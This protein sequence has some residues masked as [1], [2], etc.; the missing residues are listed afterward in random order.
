MIIFNNISFCFDGRTIIDNFSEKI[1]TNEKVCLM[2][3]SGAGKSTIMQGIMGLRHPVSGEIIV[4]N[5]TLAP[6]TV[7]LIRNRIAWVPQEINLPYDSVENCAKSLFALKVNSDKFFDKNRMFEYFDNVA[8]ERNIFNKKMNE[9]SG[10]ERQRLMI[11]F[12]LLLEKKILL[13][14]E[15]TSALDSSARSMLIEFLKSLEITMLA[16]SHDENFASSCGRII[17]IEKIRH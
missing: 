6:A 3:E 4:D 8:L 12:A 1:A 9:L 10:G 14:D 17:N 15:P 5:L 16:I 2:G 7:Q 13:L 11:V